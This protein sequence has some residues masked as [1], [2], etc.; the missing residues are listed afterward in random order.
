MSSGSYGFPRSDSPA[1]TISSVGGAPSHSGTFGQ[2][3]NLTPGTLQSGT[4]TANAV[5]NAQTGNDEDPFDDSQA[6]LHPQ[7]LNSD[8]DDE[9]SEYYWHDRVE[10]DQASGYK[11]APEI[12]SAT[13]E[14]QD[15]R[16]HEGPSSAHPTFSEIGSSE[17]DQ[18]G[19]FVSAASQLESEHAPQQAALESAPVQRHDYTREV[20]DTTGLP[21]ASSPSPAV[22]PTAEEEDS[23]GYLSWESTGS[24]AEDEPPLPDGESALD[25]SSHVAFGFNP[26][27]S[28]N[29]ELAW[30]GRMPDLILLSRHGDRRPGA[31]ASIGMKEDYRT[32]AWEA[33]TW[34]ELLAYLMW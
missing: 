23:A 6:S 19:T 5:E 15:W 33:S 12:M 25:I 27:T 11:Y 22:A 21:R 34:R 26:I 28:P 20:S 2:V 31:V 13:A 14:P 7:S 9:D 30:K 8:S 16:S 24:E 1:P 17:G 18:T 10:A 32:F 3:Q 4:S 29:H